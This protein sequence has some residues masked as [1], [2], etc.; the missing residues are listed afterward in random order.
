MK[1]SSALMCLV[2]A[3]LAVRPANAAT[4]PIS[5]AA[6]VFHET[7]WGARSAMLVACNDSGSTMRITA[8]VSGEFEK[9]YSPV[10]EAH[11]C[12]KAIFESSERVIVFD[13]AADKHITSVIAAPLPEWSWNNSPLA[14]LMFVVAG[15]LASTFSGPTA[16]LLLYPV[17]IVR[18]WFAYRIGYR[19]IRAHVDDPRQAFELNPKLIKVAKGDATDMT[20]LPS[21]L[22]KRIEQLVSAYNFWKNDPDMSEEDRAALKRMLKMPET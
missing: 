2:G 21:A 3:L 9:P 5:S 8:D 16:K 6:F 15:Y 10:V 22:Q 13:L 7:F 4:L 18:L 11:A 17:K 1:T 14:Y 20:W 19:G 12:K